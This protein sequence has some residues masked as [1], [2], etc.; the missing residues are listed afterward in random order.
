MFDLV[1]LSNVT[2]RGP[3]ARGI[4]E[5]PAKNIIQIAESSLIFIDIPLIKIHASNHYT[6]NIKIIN[7]K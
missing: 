3:Y 5:Q 7:Q 6:N 4:G 2:E 1:T